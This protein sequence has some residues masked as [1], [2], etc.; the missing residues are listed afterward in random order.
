V[1]K[2]RATV[3]YDGTDYCGFQIQRDQ[4]TIQGEIER[5]L[6]RLTQS[7]VRIS[8]AGRTDTGVHAHGQVIHFTTDWSH[9]TS[10]LERGMNA[11]LPK[12]IAVRDLAAAGESF[13]ARFD[14]V[15]RVYVYRLYLAQTRLPLLDRFECH[16]GS[17]LD[18]RQMSEAG[19][20]LIGT[21]DFAA[22]GQPPGSTTI[23]TLFDVRLEAGRSRT[24][25]LVLDQAQHLQVV[26]Q[27]NAFLRGMVRRIVGMM[28][29]VGRGRLTEDDVRGILASGDIS[30]AEPPAAACGLSLWR[31]EYAQA[32]PPNEAQETDRCVEAEP[33]RAA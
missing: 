27:G 8:A 17:E 21:H 16:A 7:D 32:G 22:F 15:R 19:R 1:L 29:A 25:M 18:L 13:H 10:A 5:A 33:K 24:G 3:A 23:R 28:L 26:V 2:Y 4:S 14:A 20:C 11:L 9:G 12:A 31:V 30:R 6:R